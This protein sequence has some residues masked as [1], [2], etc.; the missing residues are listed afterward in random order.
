MSDRSTIAREAQRLYAGGV[1]TFPAS[2]RAKHPD[3][4]KHWAAEHYPPNG[5]PEANAHA[6]MF[7]QHDV[8]R[9]FVVCGARSG[10][11]ACLDFDQAGYFEQWAA[12]VPDD[13][14]SRLYIEQSQRSGGYHVAVRTNKSASSCFPARD[15]R[16]DDGSDGDIRIEVRGEG[17]G[18]NAAPSVGYQK[19]QGDLANLPILTDEQYRL[20][21]DAA[22]TFNECDPRPQQER[23][24][25]TIRPAD[26]DELPGTRFNRESGPTEVLDIFERHG[27]TIGRKSGG[28]VSI[29]RPGATSETSGNVNPDGVTHIF[30]SNTPF[31]P[32]AAGRGN[33]H[34]PFA[35]LTTLEHGGD[36]SEA[37][38]SLAR[39]YNPK[40]RPPMIGAPALAALATQQ[41][42]TNGRSPNVPHGVDAQTG[43][44]LEPRKL[45]DLGNAERLR[46]RHGDRIRHCRALDTWFIW[47][48]ARWEPDATGH[49][50]R[51]AEE[52]VR[53]IYAEAADG[54][55]T[56]ERE[57]IAKHATRSE[58]AS[59]IEAMISL[60]R[61]LD[62]IPVVPAQLDSDRWA[63]NCVNGTLDLRSGELRAHDPANLITKLCPVVYD[64]DATLP[65]WDTFLAETTGGDEA[66][67]AFLR[68]AAG[69]TLVGEPTEEVM[70]FPY[71]PA[72]TGKSTFLEALKS[73]LGDYAMTAD[74]EA[75]L[76]K[77]SDGGIRSDIAR[78]AG[79]RFVVSIE[80][81]DG[82]RLAE[83]LF[84]ALTGGDTVTARHL[85]QREF[86]FL[87]QFA[88][89]L[90]ANNAPNVSADD[91]AMW[92]RIL[93]LPFAQIVP[94]ERRDPKIK[95]MLRDTKAAGPAIL[96][97][98]MKGCIEWQRDG[99]G[100][101]PAV[102]EATAE[103]RREMDPFADFVDA[104]C[105]LSPQS[106]IATERIWDAYRQHEGDDANLSAAAKKAF[107]GH[108]QSLGC[109]ALS[110]RWQGKVARGWK[111]IT[112]KE[113]DSPRGNALAVD[114]VDGCY[115]G[116]L[117]FPHVRLHVEKLCNQPSTPSTPSTDGDRE[118]VKI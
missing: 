70:F 67:A 3:R 75:F 48:G 56:A 94:K 73:A 110:Q 19:I 7:V 103:Y 38:R 55:T 118:R 22:A 84:K 51:F 71:G 88:L 63:L 35:V 4:V 52:T 86:E 45:T 82:K 30:S 42:Q 68:R 44:I 8:E 53:A 64:A 92:R 104:C 36:F 2:A 13:L 98:A 100:I 23:K 62:G 1:L 12:L 16:K 77:R 34:T 113:D 107:I 102:A 114:G 24:E 101:P 105:D 116:G 17:N 65:L 54:A 41:A 20:L 91:A 97:W 85:Y 10:N 27:W 78:L 31:E 39:V 25:R 49:I 60:A 117:N 99:L 90:A 11:V 6:A 47:N 106:W 72:A 28:T 18:F 74:F 57:A 33:A 59:R 93:R 89:W 81:D 95:A 108:L 40:G 5:W 83:G 14:F 37:A 96:A 50:H 79:A 26:G 66:F 80:V 29:T 43:E 112:L 69:Y 76:K 109:T 46:D 58:S 32:S 9:M 111:G 15:P 61:F 115:S 21:I 87:P